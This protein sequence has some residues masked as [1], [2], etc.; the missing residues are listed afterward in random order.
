VRWPKKGRKIALYLGKLV[1][2]WGVTITIAYGFYNILRLGPEFHMLA[3]RNKDYIYPFSHLLTSPLDPFLPYLD[4]SIKWLWALGPSVLLVLFVSGI[5]L[6]LKKYFKEII[7]L[8]GWGVVPILV[9]VEFAKVF[10]A[11][12]ILFTLPFFCIVAASVFLVKK[13]ILRRIIVA[14]L[15][16][17]VIHSLSI[18]YL[19]LTQVEAAPLPRGERSGYLEEWTAGQGIYEVSELL[20]EEWGRA[21][22]GQMVVGTE[23]Y[24]GT[25]PDGLQAYLNDIKEIKVMGVGVNISDVPEQLL[26]SKE[27][28]NRTYLVVN[29]TRFSGNPENLGLKLLAVYPKAVRLDGSREALL[30]FEVTEEA[31]NN[32]L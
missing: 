14:G 19:F 10:T 27:E 4:R 13:E 21:P 24:F 11:R 25:L 17:F 28:G 9:Q 22:E 8:V 5:V 30:F 2:L 18:D 32:N 6:N 26:N 15:I 29:N 20:R 3:I 7:L 31:V 16:V 12:Y 23:G 1:F